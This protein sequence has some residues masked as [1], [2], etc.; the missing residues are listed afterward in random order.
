MARPPASSKAAL[1]RMQRQA[2]RD[3]GPEL[4]L[5]QELHRLGLRYR[6]DRAVLP[7]FRRRA[8]VVF[9]P[10]R[11]AVFVDGCFWHVCPLHSTQP[12]A[13]A[14]WWRDK[15]ARNV[16]RDRQTDAKLTAAGWFV[17]RSWE[18]EE[19][20]AVALSI[21]ATVRMRDRQVHSHGVSWESALRSRDLVDQL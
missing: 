18:H 9:G 15:L 6:I 3:T 13:N 20:A 4:A 1:Q 11:V 8:D 21:A 5:R 14:E 16:L 2:R 7:G 12:K 10:A 17:I 19:P